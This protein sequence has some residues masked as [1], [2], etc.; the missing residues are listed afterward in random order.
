MSLWRY[1][2]LDRYVAEQVFRFNNRASKDNSLDDADRFLL[3]LS[4]RLWFRAAIRFVRV[5]LS[6]FFPVQFAL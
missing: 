3:T 5:R 6:G 2:I 4:R 1:S